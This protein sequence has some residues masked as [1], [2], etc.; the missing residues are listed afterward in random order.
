MWQRRT[1]STPLVR[2]VQV[3]MYRNLTYFTLRS[4]QKGDKIFDRNRAEASAR[5]TAHPTGN[6][7]VN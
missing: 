7:I 6:R 1:L 5:A 3:H 4:K 2:H